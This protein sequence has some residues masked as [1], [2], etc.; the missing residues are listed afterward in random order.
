MTSLAELH[1]RE[2]QISKGEAIRDGRQ[3]T[4][5]GLA[6]LV[7]VAAVKDSVNLPE[8]SFGGALIGGFEAGG[9]FFGKAIIAV[10]LG[11]AAVSG[12][13]A[14]RHRHKAR[15]ADKIEIELAQ[16]RRFTPTQNEVNKPSYYPESYDLFVPRSN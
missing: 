2:S 13:D 10:G 7:C 5:I 1:L 8:D 16:L 14:L 3:A 9:N 4:T 6:V 12:L 15:K 11:S